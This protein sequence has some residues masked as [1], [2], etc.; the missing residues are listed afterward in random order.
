MADN[1][2]I[3]VADTDNDRIVLLDATNGDCIDSF[4]TAGTAVGQF[5]S[6][7]SV[8]SDGDGGMWVGDAFNYRIQHLTLAGAS[9]GATPVPTPMAR[10]RTSSSRRTA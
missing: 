4:G 8:T 2:Q 7:R 3:L 1:G 5:K 10:T 9:L 6:P